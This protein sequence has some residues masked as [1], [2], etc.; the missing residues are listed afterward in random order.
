MYALH[1]GGAES[2]DVVGLRLDSDGSL[3]LSEDSRRQLSAPGSNPAQVGIS[4]DGRMLVMTEEATSTIGTWTLAA[5]GTPSEGSFYDSSRKAPFGFAFTKSGLLV[6]A[7]A[8]EGGRGQASISSYRVDG[9]GVAAISGAVLDQRS[10][11]CWTVLSRD[12]AFAFVTNFGDGAVSSYAL[13]PDGTLTL[14]E[15]VAGVTTADQPSVRDVGLTT[16]GQFLYAIDLASQA[17]HGWAVHADGALT[18]IG[19][20][21]GLPPAAAGLAV[22]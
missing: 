1:K 15:S 12:D 13:H 18:A 19:A 22:Q 10:E 7:N 8:E 9:N 6:V 17:V 4:P 5:D 16:D 14:L 20:W 11:V 2:G 21:P 3:T